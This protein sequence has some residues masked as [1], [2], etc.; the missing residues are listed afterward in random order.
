MLVDNCL[1]LGRDYDLYSDQEENLIIWACGAE[2]QNIPLHP[3]ML[4]VLTFSS[5]LMHCIC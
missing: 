3:K 2:K 4:A 5:L 1:L